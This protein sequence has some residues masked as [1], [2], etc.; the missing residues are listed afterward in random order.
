MREEAGEEAGD[1]GEVREEAGDEGRR[2]R[3]GERGDRG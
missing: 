3:G 1:G 2:W